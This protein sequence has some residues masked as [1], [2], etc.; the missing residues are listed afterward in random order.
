MPEARITWRR[1]L[2]EVRPAF[3][4]IAE[5][6]EFKHGVLVEK[7]GL[8]ISVDEFI[9]PYLVA[10]LAEVSA[11]YFELTDQDAFKAFAEGCLRSLERCAVRLHG[12]LSWAV[13]FPWSGMEGWLW[14]QSYLAARILH[15]DAYMALLGDVIRSWPWSESRQVFAQQVA[16]WDGQEVAGNHAFN[17]QVAAAAPA[18]MVGEAL[19]DDVL[20]SRGRGCIENVFVKSQLDA[21]NWPYDLERTCRTEP[22]DFYTL[23]T[24]WQ[25]SRLL[26]SEYWAKNEAFTSAVRRGMEYVR[27]HCMRADGALVCK[28]HWGPGYIWG[29]EGRASYVYWMLHKYLG[30]ETAAEYALRAANWLLACKPPGGYPFIGVTYGI[31]VH[32]DEVLRHL[33]QLAHQ[34]FDATGS[35]PSP[36]EHI[37]SLEEIAGQPSVVQ[38]YG[39]MKTVCQAIIGRLQQEA[40]S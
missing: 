35:V 25:A 6:F 3:K 20:L 30:D 23:V 26:Q 4:Q 1:L 13:P 39:S 17:L 16:S 37:A 14:A 40:Q 9:S 32:I 21:G 36:E 18:W 24:I 12:V 28:T 31:G 7:P 19:K 38:P 34:G 10:N 29:A 15:D 33:C 2:D 5:S 27:S 8:W 22:E 11:I